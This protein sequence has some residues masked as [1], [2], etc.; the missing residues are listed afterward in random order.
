M[1]RKKDATSVVF[2]IGLGDQ[3]DDDR[4]RVPIAEADAAS[5][6]TQ[7]RKWIVALQSADRLLIESSAMPRTSSVLA[8]AAEHR[9]S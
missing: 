2:Y 5:T 3:F 7:A 8:H 1:L 6:P 4:R 9:R